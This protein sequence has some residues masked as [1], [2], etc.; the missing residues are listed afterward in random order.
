M[1]STSG[2]PT[3]PLRD[4]V[5]GLVAITRTGYRDLLSPMP[6]AAALGRAASS[7]RYTSSALWGDNV[8]LIDDTWTTGNHAQTAAEALKSAGAGSVAVVAL[9]RHLNTRYGDMATHVEQHDFGASRGTSARC[10]AGTTPEA[11]L[12]SPLMK[13]CPT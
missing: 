6:D 4:I 2:R 3:H 12:R 9:G 10:G 8:L 5:A 7:Q 1:P 13:R 11:R